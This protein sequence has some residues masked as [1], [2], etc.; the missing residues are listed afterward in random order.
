MV[1]SIEGFWQ[2]SI[3]VGRG[4]KRIWILYAC[5]WVTRRDAVVVYYSLVVD[6][7]VA[8]WSWC[9]PTL[10]KERGGCSN[11]GKKRRY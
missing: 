2:H 11:Q 7:V 8:R 10:I 1:K 9:Q 5:A 4:R 6:L 3:A